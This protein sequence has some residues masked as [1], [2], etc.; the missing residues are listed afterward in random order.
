ME[1]VGRIASGVASRL[2]EEGGDVHLKKGRPLVI[3]AREIAGG[4][5]I[6]ICAI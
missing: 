3:C 2:V 4:D 6:S 1:T 5:L